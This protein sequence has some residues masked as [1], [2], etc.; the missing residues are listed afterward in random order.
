MKTADLIPFILL[1][2]NNGDKY[3]FELTKEIETKSNGK[4]VIKQPTLYTLLKKLEKSKFITSYWQ[5]SEIGGKRHYYKLTENGRLQVSTLPSYDFL[6]KNALSDGEEELPEIETM[7][8][9]NVS[10]PIKEEKHL[11]IMDELLNNRPEPIESVLPTEEVFADNNIDNL[12]ELDLNTNNADILKDEKVSN[13]ESFA[14]NEGVSTFTQKTKVEPVSV[15]NVNTTSIKQDLIFD[16]EFKAPVKN[17]EIKYVDY[18]NFKNTDG[19][20]Y[21]KKLALNM[22]F[23]T[24]STSGCMIALLILCSI[25]TNFTGRSTLYYIFFIGSI[26]FAVFYPVIYAINM[27]TFRL[28]YQNCEYKNNI[29]KK[30]YIGL[31]VMLVVLI[32]SII[33]NIATEHNTIGKI[34]SFKNFENLYAPLLM[35]SIVLIDLI[36][37]HIFISKLNK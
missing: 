12:T 19:Y 22:L 21:S 17:E 36:F 7:A 18:I 24:L 8:E 4:I 14:K 34:L 25:V 5:D 33:V 10:A 26:I 9:V 27:Q 28:K 35:S 23:R 1:E 6:M 3:G 29:Q 13:V 2:L 31:S 15:S 37:N 30:L 11:S 32:I 16:V 20:K